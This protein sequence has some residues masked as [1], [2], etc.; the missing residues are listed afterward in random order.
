MSLTK[1]EI[2][3]LRG[4]PA[5]P[6]PEPVAYQRSRAGFLLHR[7]GG[8]LE[9]MQVHMVGFGTRGGCA[10]LAGIRD[11]VGDADGRTTAVVVDDA[12]LEGVNSVLR[13]SLATG[14]IAGTAETPLDIVALAA[15]GQ[16]GFR[17]HPDD[18]LRLRH[19]APSRPD[20]TVTDRQ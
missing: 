17:V 19:V 3:A 1:E 2:A 16:S 12:N 13:F 20:D 9:A 4:K 14:Q 7:K 18:C 8:D 11:L 5:A 10:V 6:P 15:S